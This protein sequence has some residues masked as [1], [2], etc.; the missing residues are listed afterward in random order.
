MTRQQGI[1]LLGNW[2]VAS[3]RVSDQNSLTQFCRSAA[4]SRTELQDITD[5]VLRLPTCQELRD[6]LIYWHSVSH[7]REKSMYI[8]STILQ[9]KPRQVG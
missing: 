8:R 6:E 1:G 9:L 5:F 3:W 7:G 4:I 2:V